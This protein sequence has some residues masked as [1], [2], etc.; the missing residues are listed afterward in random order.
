MGAA[1]DMATCDGA[2]DDGVAD[3]GVIDNGVADDGVPDDGIADNF[4]AKSLLPTTTALRCVALRCVALRCVESSSKHCR[5]GHNNQI[6]REKD[7]QL[8]LGWIEVSPIAATT[9]CTS[10]TSR[11]QARSK[12]SDL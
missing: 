7:R 1:D 3:D 10:Y 4:V 6:E 9:N 8:H 5:L 11:D 2:A 12:E